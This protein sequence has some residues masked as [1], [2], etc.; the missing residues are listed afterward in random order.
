M[1]EVTRP[2]GASGGND[3]EGRRCRGRRVGYDGEGR[4]CRGDWGGDSEPV[5]AKRSKQSPKAK[6]NACA[7][8]DWVS[9]IFNQLSYD[10][11]DARSSQ[12]WQTRARLAV[13]AVR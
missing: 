10:C 11:H 5:D 6:R 1:A 2:G 12:W 3:G 9:R 13:L 8:G 4:R 7:H